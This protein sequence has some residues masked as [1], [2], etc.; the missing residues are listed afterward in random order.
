MKKIMIILVFV[1]LAG[2]F[3][4]P[5]EL[6]AQQN[7]KPAERV[8]T[9]VLIFTGVNKDPEER[10][11]KDKAVIKLRKFFLNDAGVDTEHLRVLVDSN[12][13]ARRGAELSTAEN[14]KSAVAE[15]EASITPA[16]RFIFYYVGQANAGRR[17]YP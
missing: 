2:G 13:F 10:Q 7:R 5:Y 4:L 12:S 14:L 17:C 15:L 6:H 1:V 16:D 9:Y 3:V 11:A 8:N